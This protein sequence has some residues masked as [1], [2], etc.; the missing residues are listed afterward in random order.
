V[1]FHNLLQDVRFADDQGMVANIE[2]RLQKI[3]DRVNDTAKAYDLKINVDKTKVMKVSRTGGETKYKDR[4]TEGRAT[5]SIQVLGR[6][7]H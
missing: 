6:L 4:W 5:E 3:T 2:K 1:V 7:D